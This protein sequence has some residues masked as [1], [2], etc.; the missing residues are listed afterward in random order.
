[1]YTLIYAYISIYLSLYIYI[2]I[3]IHS[4]QAP[5]SAASSCPWSRRPAKYIVKTLLYIT[6]CMCIYIYIYIVLCIHIGQVRIPR[7]AAP[8]LPGAAICQIS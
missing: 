3:Y 8:G 2:Y 7:H 1:M 5:T 6:L 4:A